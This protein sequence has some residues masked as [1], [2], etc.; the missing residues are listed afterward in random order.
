MTD[1]IE[2]NP[3]VVFPHPVSLRV[4]A[5]I[6][7]GEFI[8]SFE[9]TLIPEPASYYVTFGVALRDLEVGEVFEFE[10]NE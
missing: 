7:K 9:G 1:A 6:K 4:A 2:L 5:P 8:I 3:D 10:P